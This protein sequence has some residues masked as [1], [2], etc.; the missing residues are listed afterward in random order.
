MSFYGHCLLTKCKLMYPTHSEAKQTEMWE[1]GAEKG[2]L[3]GYVRRQVACAPPNP[4]LPKGFQQSIF[5][6]KV[7]KGRGWL[8]QTSWCRNPLFLQLST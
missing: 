2:L 7:R 5:K 6:G 1:F 4:E 8:L 3:Q